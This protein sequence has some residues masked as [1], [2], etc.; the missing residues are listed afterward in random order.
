M[1]NI[2]TDFTNY[3]DAAIYHP[4]YTPKANALTAKAKRAN[5]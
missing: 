3:N 5:S 4:M 2:Y 1:N